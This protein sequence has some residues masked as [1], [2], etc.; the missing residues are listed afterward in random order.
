M[1]M[2]LFCSNLIDYGGENYC[3]LHFCAHL[4]DLDLH[5]RQQGCKKN[6]SFCAIYFTN[7]S[8]CVDKNWYDVETVGLMN[9]TLISYHTVIFQE[10]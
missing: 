5:M 2:N 9:L 10:I 3:I 8:V 7:F 4:S 1:F 6:K